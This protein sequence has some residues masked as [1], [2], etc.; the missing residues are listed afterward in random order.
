M[1]L[2]NQKLELLKQKVLRELKPIVNSLDIKDISKF[3][4]GY[5]RYTYK[6]FVLEQRWYWD[7]IIDGNKHDVVEWEL[8]N[9]LI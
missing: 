8:L 2:S 7:K 5:E 9:P 6:E 3:N 4:K 1:I